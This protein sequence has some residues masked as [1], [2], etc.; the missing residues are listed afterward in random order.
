MERL[1]ELTAAFSKSTVDEQ[2]IG[3]FPTA[4]TGLSMR[5]ICENLG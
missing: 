1:A 3:F 2:Q 4:A 5:A